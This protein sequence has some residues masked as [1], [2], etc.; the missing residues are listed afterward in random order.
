[1][2]RTAG[3]GAPTLLVKVGA[4]EL[5]HRMSSSGCGRLLVGP[6]ANVG[7]FDQILGDSVEQV[8]A[9]VVPPAEGLAKL[10]KL[11]DVR[12]DAGDAGLQASEPAHVRKGDAAFGIQSFVID[13]DLQSRLPVVRTVRDKVIEVEDNK[14]VERGETIISGEVNMLEYAKS[15]GFDS[16]V[17]LFVSKIQEIYDHQGISLNSKHI[18]V[19]LRRMANTVIVVDAGGSEF[20]R[21]DEIEWQAVARA[22]SKLKL[23]SGEVVVFERRIRGVTEVCS[24]QTSILANI[25]FQ[26]A[27]KALA[28]AVV[29]AGTHSLSGI[30]DHIILGKLPPV[31]TG[32]YMLLAKQ[33]R[34]KREMERYRGA[35][36]CLQRTS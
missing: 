4:V 29:K 17:N 16:F 23:E 3:V 33:L 25:S 19:V 21:G 30:K 20:K 35:L 36:E 8:A 24:N 32:Y 18:E 13:P 9:V 26:G 5:A 1:M 22:N 15:H 7:A 34:E 12:A 11:F 31:G 6:G 28:K 14:H 10:S 2:V 27:V